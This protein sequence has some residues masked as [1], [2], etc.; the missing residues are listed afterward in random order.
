M[1]FTTTTPFMNLVLPEPTLELGPEWAVELNAAL[2][3]VDSHNHSPGQGVPIVSS[4]ININQDLPFNSNNA[5]LVRS[6]RFAS[7][8]A[9]LA[10]GTDLGCIYVSLGDFYY[11]NL[12]GQQVKITS[13]GTLNAASIGGIGG[14]YAT[15]GAL[16]AYTSSI[17]TYIMTIDGTNYANVN[18]AQLNI[19]PEGTHTFSVGIAASNSLATTYTLTLPLSLPSSQ[20]ALSVTSSGQILAGI[21]GGTS[22]DVLPFYGLLPTGTVLSY[23]GTSV[24]S[25]YLLCDGSSYLRTTFPNLFTVIGTACGAVDGTHFNVP[26][27]R[28][29]FLRGVDGGSGNDPDTLSR[30]AMNTGG[31][32]A[33]N[34]GSVQ[35]YQVQS[36]LH[37][38][39]LFQGGATI[40][41]YGAA[42]TSIA[43]GSGA[44]TGPTGGSET[45]PLNAYC[46]YI[47]KN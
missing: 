26:D 24:P 12:S 4:S 30:T 43:V 40:N 20:T 11:N 42:G 15:S 34:V 6:V 5:T 47:I 18:S 22:A 39:Q 2:T 8:S 10:L 45:R 19:F 7:Q 38:T 21:P 29:Y 44:N 27:L 41:A 1:S 36:H 33:D 17:S 35:G 9:P 32:T 3:L 23:F 37:N 16:V 46:Y 28:G 14:D 31:N 25:G 13:G